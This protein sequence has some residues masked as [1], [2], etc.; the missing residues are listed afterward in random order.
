MSGWSILWQRILNTFA[1]GTITGVD[2]TGPVMMLQVS[3][4]YLEGNSAIPAMQQFG[5]A[6]V[7]PLQSD[8]ALLYVAGDRSN[9]ACVGTNN[10]A[11]RFKGKQVG[12]TAV[13]NAFGMS[14]YLST[15]GIV[16]NGG[17]QPVTVNNAQ[18][19][20]INA[21]SSIELNAPGVSTSA[22]LTVGTGASGTFTAEGGVNVTVRDGII[23]NIF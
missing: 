8:A 12:E 23:T 20:V 21:A 11:T 2:D 1:P 17:G 7:P 3:I 14:I 18:S 15:A 13:F 5:F 9:G 6:S 16:I 4:G 22:N 10:Q 19:V